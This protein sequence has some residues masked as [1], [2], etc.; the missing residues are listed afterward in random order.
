MILEWMNVFSFDESL[1]PQV[2]WAEAK[3]SLLQLRSSH[4]HKKSQSWDRVTQQLS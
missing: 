4:A 1:W 2:R 3:S